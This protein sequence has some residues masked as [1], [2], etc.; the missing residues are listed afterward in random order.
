MRAYDAWHGPSRMRMR[1]H[2]CNAHRYVT[3]D[4]QLQAY[5]MLQ[6]L[7]R[8]AKESVTEAVDKNAGCG[9]SIY[10]ARRGT[11]AAIGDLPDVVFYEIDASLKPG[12]LF[13]EHS[14]T[15]AGVCECH[16][17]AKT[18]CELFAM[19]IDDLRKITSEI[20][21]HQVSTCPDD[22]QSALRNPGEVL[23]THT[24]PP[25]LAPPH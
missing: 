18:R 19:A 3:L 12:S 1:M 11:F 15:S 8:E 10:F 14:L 23:C 7:L 13:G 2:A 5:H 21:S 20:A 4:L 25:L 17:R 6:P 24:R 22:G 9:P 16:Y